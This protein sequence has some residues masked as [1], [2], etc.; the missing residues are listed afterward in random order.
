MVDSVEIADMDR[1]A[2]FVNRYRTDCTYLSL[3][4]VFRFFCR[5]SDFLFIAARAV[6]QEHG[7]AEVSYRKPFSTY[8]SKARSLATNDRS[9]AGMMDQGCVS[10]CPARRKIK[11]GSK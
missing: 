4:Q 2:A 11:N 7:A 3:M 5:M 1:V 6:A 9:N 8:A 10:A